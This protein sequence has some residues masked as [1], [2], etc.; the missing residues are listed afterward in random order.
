MLMPII[1]KITYKKELACNNE[2]L[3][4]PNSKFLHLINEVTQ[5]IH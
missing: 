5:V 4:K 1:S 3:T 2:L